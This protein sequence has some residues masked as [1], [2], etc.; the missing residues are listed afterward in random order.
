[1]F[2]KVEGRLKRLNVKFWSSSKL[3]LNLRLCLGINL[4]QKYKNNFLSLDSNMQPLESEADAYAHLP[5][6]STMP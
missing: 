4:K 2:E 6:L 3:N 5:S 1:M